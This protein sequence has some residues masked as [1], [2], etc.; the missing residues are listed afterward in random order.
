MD[1]N[2]SVQSG[3]FYRVILIFL[4]GPAERLPSLVA[5]ERAILVAME[6]RLDEELTGERL[7]RAC[8]DIGRET[9]V[10]D[11]A[12]PVNVW[13]YSWMLETFHSCR[14]RRLLSAT[15]SRSP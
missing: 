14:H 13:S 15:I 9:C 2:G 4:C 6:A 11:G 10:I 8:Q 3:A 12:V 7:A 1:M 5:A